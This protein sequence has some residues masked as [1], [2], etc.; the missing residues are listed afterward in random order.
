M[1]VLSHYN[2]L[3]GPK[4]RLPGERLTDDLAPE[5]QALSLGSASARWAWR[6]RNPGR[7]GAHAAASWWRENT[8]EWSNCL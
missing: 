6:S 5:H 8:P 7:E 4:A 3:P 1:D 2:G